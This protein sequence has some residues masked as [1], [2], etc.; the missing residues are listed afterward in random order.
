MAFASDKPAD[1]KFERIYKKFY[2]KS[3]EK[4]AAEKFSDPYK[5]DKDDDWPVPGWLEDKNINYLNDYLMVFI[6]DY[7]DAREKNE[8]YY[9]TDFHEEHP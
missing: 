3:L 5:K 6:A 2:T 9:L 7:K 8:K 4:L 1:K